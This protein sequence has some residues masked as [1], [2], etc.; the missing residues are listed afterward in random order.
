MSQDSTLE[1]L[2]SGAFVGLRQMKKLN[3][4]VNKRTR[5]FY[6]YNM[7]NLYDNSVTGIKGTRLNIPMRENDIVSSFAFPI[8]T[9]SK[10]ERK[11]IVERLQKNNIECRPLIA[12]FITENNH[13]LRNI[14]VEN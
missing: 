2:T 7:Y 5:N 11:K 3:E 4:F 13:F 1:I 10:E 12:R 8:L 6:L 14:M 9:S